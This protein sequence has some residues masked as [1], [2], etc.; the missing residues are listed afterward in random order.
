MEKEEPD[1]RHNKTADVEFIHLSRAADPDRFYADP[2]RFNA[3]PDP[4]FY[5]NAD[6][7]PAFYFNAEEDA[8]TC[9]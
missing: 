1:F 7:D 6:P 3:D 5:F 9:L 8:T 4:A 2:D